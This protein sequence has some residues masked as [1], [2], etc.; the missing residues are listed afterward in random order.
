MVGRIYCTITTFVSFRP[1]PRTD[2]SFIPELTK[3]T[4]HLINDVWGIE[5]LAIQQ[6]TKLIYGSSKDGF[7]IEM[8]IDKNFKVSSN[9]E[10][11][12][13]DKN[14]FFAAG[15]YRPIRLRVA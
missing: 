12:F 5:S 11:N 10:A 8:Q 14:V 9:S 4:K 3:T 15:S 2:I 13:I 7:I 6:E 1:P